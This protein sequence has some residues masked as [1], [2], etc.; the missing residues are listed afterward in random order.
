MIGSGIPS[1]HSKSPRPIVLLLVWL[2][3]VVP[4]HVN[5][6]VAEKVPALD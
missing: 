3:A 6:K 4:A 5:G 1:I 2:R